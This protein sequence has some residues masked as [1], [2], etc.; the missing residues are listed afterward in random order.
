MLGKA[1]GWYTSELSSLSSSS[2]QIGELC[3]SIVYINSGHCSPR[4]KKTLI[5]RL[6]AYYLAER[7]VFDREEK[8]TIEVGYYFFFYF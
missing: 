2:F 6:K 8:L 3:G 7:C 5:T 1:L 4:K